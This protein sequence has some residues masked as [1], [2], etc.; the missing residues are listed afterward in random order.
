MNTNI[1]N[2]SFWKEVK[3][4]FSVEENEFLCYGSHE[5]ECAWNETDIRQQLT[6]LA[7]DFLSEA[8]NKGCVSIGDGRSRG[9]LFAADHELQG[10]IVRQQFID[11]NIQR[12]QKQ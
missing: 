10:R 9:I 1:N 6:Q 4:E 12:L 7:K 3:R 8:N 5:F 2:I 11:W